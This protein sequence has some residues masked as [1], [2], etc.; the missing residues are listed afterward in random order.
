MLNE[1]EIK[2]ICQAAINLKFD[3]VMPHNAVAYVAMAQVNYDS[4]VYT[5][6]D[7]KLIEFLYDNRDLYPE[8]FKKEEA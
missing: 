6:G 5:E 2:R 7:V 4:K 1:F 3:C 8:L